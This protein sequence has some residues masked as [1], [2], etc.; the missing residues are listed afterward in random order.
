[1]QGTQSG[2]FTCGFRDLNLA[3]HRK[4]Y[5]DIDTVELTDPGR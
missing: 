5:S 2:E 3:I 4:N 1:M